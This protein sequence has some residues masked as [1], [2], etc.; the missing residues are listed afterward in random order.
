MFITHH[1]YWKLSRRYDYSFT[2]G[3]WLRYKLYQLL[4]MLVSPDDLHTADLKYRTISTP[5][6]RSTG[7]DT[8]P[9]PGSREDRYLIRDGRRNRYEDVQDDK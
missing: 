5:Y 8:P 6:T 1:R 9:N 4:L 7:K 3:L 2:Q